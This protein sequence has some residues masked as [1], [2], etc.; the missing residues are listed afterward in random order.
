M[1][2]SSQLLHAQP[3]VTPDARP[4]RKAS[5]LAAGAP[6]TPIAGLL[7]ALFL[8]AQILLQQGWLAVGPA[9]DFLTFYSAAGAA[10]P[11][12]PAQVRAARPPAFADFEA[13]SRPYLR[14]PV[15]VLALEPLRALPY[16][17]AYQIYQVVMLW[18]L[19]G[20][21]WW[22]LPGKRVYTLALTA[23]SLPLFFGFMRGSDVPLALAAYAGCVFAARH[24]K[25]F[26]AGLSLSLGAFCPPALLAAPLVVFARRSWILGIGLL[27]GLMT[28]GLASFS[29]GGPEWPARFFETWSSA[30]AQPATM[31]NLAGLA[32]WLNLTPLA[33]IAG[34]L[35]LAIAVFAIS[36]RESLSVSLGS[37]LAA[38]LLIIPT[39]Y[40]EDAALLLPAAL[41]LV[42]DKQGKAVRAG[43]IL[44]LTPLGFVGSGAALPVVALVAFVVLL[45]AAALPSE[46]AAEPAPQPIVG[47]G[48]S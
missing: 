45:L 15:H 27:T 4:R 41:A 44:L 42:A 1:S 17:T 31:P 34:A 21:V 12:S 23:L 37:A 26:L 25:P 18:C 43:A 39:A 30:A 14:L 35:A 33:A 28:L 7:A 32:A 38:G 46:R 6:W 13:E 2:A 40:L 16:P 24:K 36:R 10:D 22:W 47:L 29:R 3:S 9:N 19:A 20:F 11:Y 5:A 8:A 48:L